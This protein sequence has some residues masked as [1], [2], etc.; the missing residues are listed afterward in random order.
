VSASVLIVDDDA[1]FR[2]LAHRLLTAAGLTVIGEASDAATAIA[3]ANAS[4]P[5]G[6]LVD[7]RLPDRDG[8]ELARELLALDWHPHVLLTS[9]DDE[10]A[11][12]ARSD[13][14]EAL[15]FVPKEALPFVPKEDLPNAPLHALLGGSDQAARATGAPG[16]CC[17][18]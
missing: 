9:S 3:A 10:S 17:H 15:P 11:D 18:P 7:L 14:E 5:D 12:L 2:R 13:P 8:L 16:P 1:A 4:R 6:V